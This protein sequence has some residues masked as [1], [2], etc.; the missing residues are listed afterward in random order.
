MSAIETTC[1]AGCNKPFTIFKTIT[2]E[3]G[4]GI[5][6]TSFTCPHC[7]HKYVM[8]YTDPE[9][10]KLQDKIQKVL[11]QKVRPNLRYAESVKQEKKIQKQAERVNKLIGEKMMVLREK[12]ESK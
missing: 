12:V 6:E 3:I 5:V 10:R 9:I 8:F 2:L 1:D 7:H 11:Q 4:S